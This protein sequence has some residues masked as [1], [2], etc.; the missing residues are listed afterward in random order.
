MTARPGVVS[1]AWVCLALA[2]PGVFSAACATGRTEP[3]AVAGGGD[4]QNGQ[5][6]IEA[7][8]CVACHRVPGVSSTDAWVGPPLDAWSRRAFIAGSVPNSA[9]NLERWLT[10]PE[11]VRPG[12][13]MPDLELT[14]AEIADLVAYL[15]TLE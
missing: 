3:P 2:C 14:P 4:P 5:R 11:Q 8:G 7:R 6:L 9:E 1:A 13:A 10:D 12:T 15:F